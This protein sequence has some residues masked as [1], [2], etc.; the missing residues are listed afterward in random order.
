MGPYHARGPSYDVVCLATGVL[1]QQGTRDP[2][3]AFAQLLGLA[4]KR[5]ERLEV[6]AD[7]VV[8]FAVAGRPLTPDDFGR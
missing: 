6:T 5:G 8:T 7:L 1:M 2:D 3:D 4:I